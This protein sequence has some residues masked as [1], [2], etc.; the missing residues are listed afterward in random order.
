[1]T[2]LKNMTQIKTRETLFIIVLK[3]H[4][5]LAMGDCHFFICSVVESELGC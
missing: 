3:S 5:L 4:L 2:P 1:M